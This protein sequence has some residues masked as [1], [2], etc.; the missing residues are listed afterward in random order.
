MSEI[1]KPPHL[2]RP[3]ELTPGSKN[4]QWGWSSDDVWVMLSSARAGH[5]DVMQQ[6]LERDPTLV[7]CFYWYTSPL[8]FAVREGHLNTVQLLI[9]Y[10]ADSNERT[11]YGSE[12]CLQVAEDRGHVDVANYLRVLNPNIATTDSALHRA[13]QSKDIELAKTILKQQPEAINA[14]GERGRTPLHYA[15]D[16]NDLDLVKFVV[17]AG[18][19][20][21]IEA[22]SNDNRL[23]SEGFRPV[24]SAL[25]HHNY[26]RQ[27]NNY[28]VVDFLLQHGA[29]YNLVV[30]A[31]RGDLDRVRHLLLREQAD[32]NVSEACGKRAL[33]AAAERNHGHIVQL[34]L[35]HG[36]KPNLAEGPNCPNGYALWA[37]A[38]GGYV[39]IVEMLLKHHADPNAMVESSG[40]PTDSTNSQEIRNLLYQHG[41]YVSLAAH[42]HQGNIDTVAALLKRC[43][44]VF[45]EMETTNAFTAAVSNDDKEL[46]KLLLAYDLRVPKEVTCCQ[47]YLWKSLELADILLQHGMD[48]NLPNWQTIRPLHHMAMRGDI[49]AARLFLKYGADVWAVDEEYCSTPLGWAARSGQVEFVQ[50]LLDYQPELK[51]T[52]PPFEKDWA[53]PMSW[54]ARRGFNEIVALLQ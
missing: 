40:S 25:W 33:S 36:A 5:T 30:A 18:A 53:T 2:S 54:A 15:V 35:D 26:W 4:N 13:I 22:H 6:L 47:T 42:F 21:D 29:E 49:D 20:V 41:G 31:A 37:A 8:H 50:F 39:E 16:T 51:W 3:H 23:G 7:H 48:P 43:K 14:P 12:S 9:D 1:N 45:N 10:G 38:R 46:L 32:P 17:Y 19:T 27:K 11:L 28:D 52:R 44:Q 24:V 34:L